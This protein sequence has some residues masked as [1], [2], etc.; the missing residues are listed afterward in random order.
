MKQ[1]H[2]VLDTDVVG[3]LELYFDPVDWSLNEIFEALLDFCSKYPPVDWKEV[4]YPVGGV[5]N[6]TSGFQQVCTF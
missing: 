3:E 2:L 4:F 1:S 6:D 5:N